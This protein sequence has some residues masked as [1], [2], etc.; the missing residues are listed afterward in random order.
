MTNEK[1][2]DFYRILYSGCS[3]LLDLGCC[4]GSHTKH[5][6]IPNKMFVD[7]EKRA[8]DLNP[9]LKAD[10]RYADKLFTPKS[11]NIVTALDVIEH[12]SKDEGYK[13]LQ[14]MELI[15]DKR[16]LIFSPQGDYMIGN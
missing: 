8:D 2:A 14:A 13:L 15:A 9:F 5:W 4:E 11:Y 3:S 12:L 6:D 1:V 7:I 16:I 10:I